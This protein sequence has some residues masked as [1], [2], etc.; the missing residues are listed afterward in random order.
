M[1][2]LRGGQEEGTGGSPEGQA[3]VYQRVEAI[4]IISFHV[5]PDIM[6]Q[7]TTFTK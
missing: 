7:N 1:K 4:Q 5:A 3:G 6:E 2:E